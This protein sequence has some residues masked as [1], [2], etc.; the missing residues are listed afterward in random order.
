LKEWE[1][2]YVFSDYYQL[3]ED[4]GKEPLYFQYRGVQ[5]VRIHDIQ[6]PAGGGIILNRHTLGAALAHHG[7]T[8]V[9]NCFKFENWTIAFAA[10]IWK[11]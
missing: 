9:N 2:K 11:K 6:S 4:Y 3:F 5:Y 8:L 7:W 1:R 10:V